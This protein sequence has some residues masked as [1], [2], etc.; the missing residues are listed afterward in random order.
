MP[1]DHQHDDHHKC[2][3][4]GYLGLVEENLKY[5]T[6]LTKIA[7][8]NYG[9]EAREIARKALVEAAKK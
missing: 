9:R 1:E 8:V 2:G 5:R 4:C 3:K 6:A 7:D